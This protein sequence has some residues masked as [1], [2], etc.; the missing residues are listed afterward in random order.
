MPCHH[1]P[2]QIPSASS[3]SPLKDPRYSHE[4]VRSPMEMNLSAGSMSSSGRA[5]LS[6]SAFSPSGAQQ[7]RYFFRDSISH[8]SVPGGK[9][10]KKEFGLLVKFSPVALDRELDKYELSEGYRYRNNHE[11]ILAVIKRRGELGLISSS[12][13]KSAA[14]LGQGTSPV[15]RGWNSLGQSGVAGVMAGSGALGAADSP[16]NRA[17]MRARQR[18]EFS[19]LK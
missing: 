12:P 5:S 3:P 18:A 1:P 4:K 10:E 14:R 7:K 13:D 6:L 11:K 17:D 15:A 16:Q 8:S 19:R 2:P 9:R